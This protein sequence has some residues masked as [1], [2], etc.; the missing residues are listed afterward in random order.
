[1]S[2]KEESVK[3]VEVMFSEKRMLY[4]MSLVLVGMFMLLCAGA[5]TA[6]EEKTT[7]TIAITTDPR[8][9]S[10]VF[11]STY[12]DWIVGYRCYSSLFQADENFQPSPDLAESWEVSEDYLTYTFHLKKDATFHDGSPITAEDV[13]F[14]VMEMILP[15]CNVC[16]R[17]LGLVIESAEAPDEHTVVFHLNAAYPEFLNPYDG[18]GPTCSGVVKK[19]LYEGTNLLTNP[20]NYEPVGSGPFKFVEWVR[21]S[22][23]IFERYEEYHGPL[24]EIERIVFKILTD[25]MMRAL[26]FEKGEVQY[27]P[28]EMTRSEVPRLDSLPGNNVFFHGSPCGTME[29]LGFN[30]RRA[31]FDSK[32]VRKA[33]TAA[34]DKQTI[35][36]LV[37]FGGATVGTGHIPLTPFSAWWQNPDAKQIEYDPELSALMLDEAGYPV[38]EDGWRFHINL[39]HTTG[40]S[41]HLKI[42]EV[43]KDAFNKIDVDL[44]IISLDHAA[45]HE[46][47]F[48]LW[49]FDTS[50]LPYC[51]GP[52]PSTMFRFHTDNIKPISW[53]NAAGF[54]NTEYDVLFG[55]MLSELN[56][57]KRIRYLY[58]MQ[59][60]L[61]EEQR[62]V[63]TVHSKNGTALKEG[64]FTEEP[65]NI[66]VLGYNWM[67]FDRVKPIK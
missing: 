10:P 58:R 4:I 17:G 9:I 41:E 62:V 21:G 50:I 43:I 53:A 48:Q 16:N 8:G 31:P 1:M 51:G 15:N 19:E 20:Y 65:K 3:E 6:A 14:S 44:R 61:A 30:I 39:K 12:H 37:Y 34:I 11:A 66:W 5:V 33:L 67:H 40:Y 27:V 64:L 22:H 60:I 35:V 18:L 59:E 29:E 24:P 57:E 42:A 36:D 28:F 46:Q 23:I 63:F 45:W 47:V 56:E 13:I 52:N 38:K 2:S 55:A 7:L 49:D 32:V 26:S 25:P 54:S